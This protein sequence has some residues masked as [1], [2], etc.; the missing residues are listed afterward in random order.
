MNK[1]IIVESPSKSKTIGTY[2]GKG[3]T[4]LS[5][6]GH[7]CD[8]ATT[9]KEGLGIDC[10]HGFI[11]TY[12]INK[13]KKELVDY[14]IK[15]CK[16]KEV[17]LATD[18][19][20]EG[21][22]IAY[23]LARELNLNLD[24]N[25]RIEFHEITK[26]AVKEALENPHKIDLKMV[27]SQE[28]RRMIDRILGFKLSK[29]MQRKINSKSAGRVQSVAL[30]LIVNLEREIL[31][32]VPVVYFDIDAEYKD[33]KIKLVEV[34][35]EKFDKDHKILKRDILDDLVA[36]LKEFKVS[37]I[38]V[39]NVKRS[40]QPTYT[41]S[42]LQQDAVNRLNFTP[43][44]TMSV[45]QSLYEGK[46]IGSETVGLI[47][48]MRTDSTRLAESFVNDAS[49][50]I[51]NNFGK[52]YL[53]SVKVRNQKGMQDAHEGIRPTSIDRTPDS[54]KNYL[55]SDEYK[56]YKLIYNRT[57]SSLMASSV[58]KSTV[59]SLDNFNS[60]WTMQSSELTFE[61]YLSVY[62]D[63]DEEEESKLPKLEI[64][65]LF[66]AD[67]INVVEKETEPKKRYTEATLIKEMENLGIGRPSTYATTIQVLKERDYVTLDKK[68]LV[69]TSQGILT[70]EKLQEFFSPIIN[71]KYTA[72]METALDEIAKGNKDKKEELTEF[73]DGFMPLFDKAKENMK[74]KYPIITDKT[75]PYCGHLLVIR[76]GKFGEFTSCSNY[77]HCNYIE[78]VDTQAEFIG[79]K[80]PSCDGEIV[81]RESKRGVFYSCSNYPKCNVTF[82]DMPTEELC[83][84]C[85]SIMLKDKNGNLYCSAHCESKLDD[86]Y[87]CPTCGQGH[88][89]I[90]TASRGKNRGHQFYTCSNY[91][92]CKTILLGKPTHEVCP[93]CNSMMVINESG[94]LVCNNSCKDKKEVVSTGVKCP[95]CGK[96]ELVL[97][98]A[99]KGKNKG[100]DFY[101][102]S[103]FP[104]CKTIISKE[105]FVK[106]K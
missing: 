25:N 90:K 10:E 95:N 105:E 41:T 101:G 54:L 3:Y 46:N 72:N 45:A 78:K 42:T 31:S 52:E 12:T 11:P 68:N 94:N 93:N 50:Y 73:Y 81:R 96:G 71:V 34:N 18:P 97:R 5:S 76:N 83:P 44:K 61:G 80:C 24:S 20:R 56:L 15:E 48:Y 22:A 63:N 32:F 67:Y 1:V 60:K 106:L 66:N 102:C 74:S 43:T 8:L 33:T 7:I 55:T 99:K 14:L 100:E 103:N 26:T 23:H 57:L 16:N 28:S 89:V 84:K 104:K 6:K 29:L 35:G 47:T 13:D 62:K 38:D 98:N 36:N 79:V 77:P 9:G 85:G 65:S 40:S 69:P 70:T 92:K 58:Y 64:G 17:L 21:E 53:G 19:D 59:I 91:P 86:T 75:C 49:R 27:D 30:L 51:L 82:N 4:V 39:K 2:L 37:A 88:I 87:I